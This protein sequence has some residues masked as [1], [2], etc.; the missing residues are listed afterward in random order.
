M[1]YLRFWDFFQCLYGVS[2]LNRPFTYLLSAW[3]EHWLILLLFFSLKTD[4]LGECV[5][6]RFFFL[7]V[8][9]FSGLYSCLYGHFTAYNCLGHSD[10]NITFQLVTLPLWCL[11]IAV[12]SG[13][14]I[15]SWFPSF[16]YVLVG[17]CTSP[18][19][20]NCRFVPSWTLMMASSWNASMFF[21]HNK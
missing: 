2:R 11:I 17:L 5:Q 18:D 14:F 6:W 20:L 12:A 21:A 3:F 15:H 10:L 7:I 19:V 1:D 4:G 9:C 8:V 16:N 13:W